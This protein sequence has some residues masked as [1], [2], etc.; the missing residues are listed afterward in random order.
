MDVSIAPGGH[1]LVHCLEVLAQARGRGI[2]S[3]M[4]ASLL[5]RALMA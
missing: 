1:V 2:G 3:G 5:R 4:L